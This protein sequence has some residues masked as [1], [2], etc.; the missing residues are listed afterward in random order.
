MHL[1]TITKFLNTFFQVERYNE[2]EQGGI[3][4]PSTR[5]IKRLGLALEPWDGLYNWVANQHIDALFLHRPWKLDVEQLPPDIGVISYHLPFDESLTLGFNTRLADVLSFSNL[6]VFGEKQNRP[7]GMIGQAPNQT[8]TDIFN[9]VKEI[10]NGYEQ[11]RAASENEVKK[12]AVVGAMTDLL[13]REAASHGVNVY[14]TGQLRQPAAQA[15]IDTQMSVIAVG[16]YRCEIWG[17]HT[18]ASILQQRWSKLYL[19]H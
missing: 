12:V 2:D 8:F 13:V 3:Y 9:C 4:L 15:V 19:V 1:D 18:L 10:F 6:E 17:L 11:I 5:S 16:H 7:I 14:I